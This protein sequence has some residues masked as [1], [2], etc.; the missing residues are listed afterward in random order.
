[1]KKTLL[2][3]ALL[4]ANLFLSHPVVAQVPTTASDF[5]LTD[6][7]GTAHNLFST[8]DKGDV[9]AMEVVM[10]CLP[11]VQGRKALAKIEAEYAAT[12]PGKFHI[13]TFGFTSS[14]DCSSIQ[15]WMTSNNVSGVS[16]AGDDGVN[17]D[18]GASGGMPTIILVGGS[19]HKVLYWKQGFANKDTVAMKTAIAKI[20]TQASVA[21]SNSNESLSLYP[22]PS[23]NS[24]SLK[25]NCLTSDTRQAA[26]YN[27]NGVNVLSIFDGKL[28]V[29]EH[30]INFSTNAL[31]SGKYYL[32]VTTAGKTSVLP[33][34]IVH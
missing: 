7:D 28:S 3:F 18:Y 16:F 21:S 4:A 12:H 23:A 17:T 14:V 22:N 9:V 1:M 20:L 34:T 26:L 5:T 2:V 11:C 24:T 19:D 29:G 31:A 32:H 30:T 25:I 13:Y 33:L 15:Q 10:G 6:C 27:T 8:L